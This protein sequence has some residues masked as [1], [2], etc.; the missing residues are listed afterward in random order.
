MFFSVLASEDV[1][2]AHVGD[3][4]ELSCKVD[5]AKCGELHSVKWYRDTSRIYVY[6]QLGHVFR[7]EGDATERYIFLQ[8]YN[9]R[10]ILR[11][12]VIIISN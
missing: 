12:L 9:I 3:S 2:N 4:V 6:S 1:N 7:A 8:N 10:E 5:T 11:Y